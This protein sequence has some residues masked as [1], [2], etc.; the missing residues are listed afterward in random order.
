MRRYQLPNSSELGCFD[1][2][3]AKPG[4]QTVRACCG[5]DD[6]P[7]CFLGWHGLPRCAVGVPIE[8][9]DQ[10]L[11]DFRNSGLSFDRVAVGNF[12]VMHNFQSRIVLSEGGA[13][14]RNA[15]EQAG[16]LRPG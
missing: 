14:Q 6:A 16:G 8:H 15:G 12:P 3:N 13:L 4:R 1:L 11:R 5:G 9:L 7:D 10:V 2:R